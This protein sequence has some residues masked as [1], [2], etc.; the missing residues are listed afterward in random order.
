MQSNLDKFMFLIAPYKKLAPS[1]IT[2][3]VRK[4]VCIRTLETGSSKFNRVKEF[5]GN[6]YGGS[7]LDDSN[8]I[9]RTKGH[10][11]KY[12]SEKGLVLIATTGD[13]DGLFCLQF[14]RYER[15]VLE[16]RS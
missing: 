6:T 9:W 8:S 4:Y 10:L 16:G 1:Y 15:D 2:R 3:A 14:A 7:R 5:G 12:I 13:I 11:M